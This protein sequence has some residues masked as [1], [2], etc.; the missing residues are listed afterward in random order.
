M[1]TDFATMAIMEA[2]EGRSTDISL[3]RTEAIL[4]YPDFADWR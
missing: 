2:L 3:Q 4:A 1:S